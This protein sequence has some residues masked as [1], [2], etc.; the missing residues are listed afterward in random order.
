MGVVSAA[1]MFIF[2]FDIVALYN[3]SPET[4]EMAETFITILCITMIGTVYE[5]PVMGGI[6]SGGGDTKYQAIIDTVFMWILVV[7]LSALSA[8]VFHW[9][10]VVTFICLKCDQIL[11]CIP[12]AIY[13]NSYKWI[14]DRTRQEESDQPETIPDQPDAD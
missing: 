8:F 1:L 13:G 11:K 12:N 5:Y 4:K 14:K 7:P 2:R 3:I 6:I 10:P 9:G